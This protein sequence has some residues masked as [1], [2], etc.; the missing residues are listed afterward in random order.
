MTVS[1]RCNP[2][3]CQSSP[4]KI[5]AG[6]AIACSRHAV[7]QIVQ[8]GGDGPLRFVRAVLDDHDRRFRIGASGQ[9]VAADDRGIADTH[10]DRE[11]RA[12][13]R[14]R[15]PIQLRLAVG[16]GAGYDREL[17]H[18]LAQRYGQANARGARMGGRHA[19]DHLDVDVR[20]L[21]GR[22]FLGCA[23]EDQRIAAL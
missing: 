19:R 4:T 9:Q 15:G 17:A 1:G 8:G 12:L 10:V 14:Q 2:A 11:G 22:H 6:P 23:A 16:G 13:G 20:G 7:A 5:T 21:Q 3:S 18:V